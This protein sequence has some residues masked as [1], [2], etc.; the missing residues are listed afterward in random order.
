MYLAD[1]MM[2]MKTTILDTPIDS[3][4][5]GHQQPTDHCY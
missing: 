4:T 1:A 3:P 5:I 2:E